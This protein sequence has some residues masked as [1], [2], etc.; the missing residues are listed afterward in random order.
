MENA[1]TIEQKIA[2]ALSN[3]A[4]T[5]ADI[6]KLIAETEAAIIE[7][8]ATAE[9]ERSKALDPLL[10]PDADHARSG[11]DAATFA[12]DR[13]RTVLPRL[14]ARH[15]ETVAAEKYARWLPSYE[16]AKAKQEALA[17]EL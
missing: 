15:R 1:M 8:D 7:A 17:D 2:S 16:A 12:R 11:M 5:S 9:T 6:A 3:D 14:Q 4:I 10:S 13:L